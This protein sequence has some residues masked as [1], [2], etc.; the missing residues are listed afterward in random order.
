MIEYLSYEKAVLTITGLSNIQLLK[1]LL[2]NCSN[3][4]TTFV[5]NFMKKLPGFKIDFESTD[6][7]LRLH[8]YLWSKIIDNETA[9]L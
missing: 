2:F 9:A 3:F 1:F 5:K 6:K 4:H 8:Q 7:V